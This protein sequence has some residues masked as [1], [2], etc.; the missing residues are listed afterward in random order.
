MAA[1]LVAVVVTLVGVAMGIVIASRFSSQRAAHPRSR[2]ARWTVILLGG[3]AGAFIASQLYNLVHE[4]QLDS[5]FTTG[6]LGFGR[7]ARSLEEIT[8]TGVARNIF[9]YGFLLIG[10][11]V[12]VE[13]IAVRTL[14]EEDP[15]ERRLAARSTGQETA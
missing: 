12:A 14:R 11:A 15:G 6:R 9:F 8:L 4:L 2:I 3:T 5:Q 1:L 10:L 13:L 7:V